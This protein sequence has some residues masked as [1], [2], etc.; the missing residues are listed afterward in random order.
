MPV[1]PALSYVCVYPL[2]KA[3]SKNLH[4]GLD[5]NS[6]IVIK[7]CD[8]KSYIILSEP[9]LMS[10]LSPTTFES[11]LSPSNKVLSLADDIIIKL[12][13]QK[14][15]KDVHFSKNNEIVFSLRL[16][17]FKCLHAL[18][19]KIVNNIT[20]L[21]EYGRRLL[22]D[23]NFSNEEFSLTT[24]DFNHFLKDFYQSPSV[25]MQ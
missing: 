17:E 16:N 22:S 2:N 12:A 14:R 1:N 5:I 4:I 21:R 23:E 11:L 15:I 9:S 7:L 20:R 10:C 24:R 18:S 25:P 19:D 13:Q 8:R 6:E 3:A